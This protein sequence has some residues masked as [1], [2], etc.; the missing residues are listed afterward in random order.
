MVGC[1]VSEAC[2]LFDPGMPGDVGLT[3]SEVIAVVGRLDPSRKLTLAF[4]RARG[5]PFSPTRVGG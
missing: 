3:E 5:I 1:G 4:I 2:C